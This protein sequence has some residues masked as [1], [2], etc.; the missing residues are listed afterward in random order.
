MYGH[1]P[2]VIIYLEKDRVPVGFEGAKVVLF[3]RV[4]GAKRR[5]LDTFLRYHHAQGLSK[6]RYTVDEI[7]AAETLAD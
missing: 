5:T 1:R 6:R 2:I 3:V 7:F 4:V